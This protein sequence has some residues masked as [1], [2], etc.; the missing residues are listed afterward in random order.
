MSISKVRALAK[1]AET[2]SS[3][4]MANSS[5]QSFL[6]Y[7]T[8]GGKSVLSASQ[9]GDDLKIL[10]LSP[11]GGSCHLQSEFPNCVFYSIDSLTELEEIVKDLEINMTII[12]KLMS[13]TDIQ[14]K[15]YKEKIFAKNYPAKEQKEI[16]EEDWK[17]IMSCV[18]QKRFPFDS[19]VLEEMDIVSA[20]IMDEVEKTFDLDIIGEDKK[21]MSAD[22]AELRRVI[23]AF[24]SRLLKLPVRTIFATSDKTPKEVQGATQTTPNICTGA[25]ARM[26]LGMIGN[27]LYVYKEGEKYLVR[28]LP[29]NQYLI[30]TKLSPVKKKIE[31]PEVMDVTNCPEKFWEFVSKVEKIRDEE[32]KVIRPVDI[33]K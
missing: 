31:I 24:Y 14:R 21:K 26:L 33:K 6:F 28:M 5:A 16:M 7:G 17:D 30:R 29:N 23:V 32:N 1:T 18:E 8:T 22:W 19:V 27:V 15:D 9:I 3:N 11:A 12:K 2:K 4:I 10:V 25:A 20:W 13:L